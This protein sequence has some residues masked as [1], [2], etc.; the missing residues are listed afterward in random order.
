[1]LQ[2]FTWYYNSKRYKSSFCYEFRVANWLRSSHACPLASIVHRIRYNSCTEL[3]SRSPLK[4][5]I[6]I[7]AATFETTSRY[8]RVTRSE[9]AKYRCDPYHSYRLISSFVAWARAAWLQS[10]ENYTRILPFAPF[11]NEYLISWFV[12]CWCYLTN[13]ALSFDQARSNGNT[14]HVISD[15]VRVQF[16]I[17]NKFVWRLKRKRK[18]WLFELLM[19]DV[20]H[21][22]IFTLERSVFRRAIA[23][24]H[25]WRII[26][27][28]IERTERYRN[29]CNSEDWTNRRDAR[30]LARAV[31]QILFTLS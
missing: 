21:N 30:R 13:K 12:E 14:A 29:V 8:E 25:W 22:A 3:R 1:M 20:P 4:F 27:R 19:F 7:A 15:H 10:V 11:S 18:L 23:S 2:S 26:M 28:L 6:V 31:C 17:S 24:V 5:E 16:D 9:R